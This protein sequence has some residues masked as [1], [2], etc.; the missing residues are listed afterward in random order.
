MEGFDAAVE[1]NKIPIGLWG[2][3]AVNWILDN[4]G[5]FIDAITEGLRVPINGS[6]DLL[7]AIPS[8]IFI[9]IAAAVTYAL[10]RSWKLVLFVVLGLL[11]ILNPGL[12]KELVAPLVLV[13]YA[14]GLA[15]DIDLRSEEGRAGGGW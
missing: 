13:I 10:Q 6:V 3:Y 8:P 12:W 11:L 2:R 1:G 9:L 15:L 14:T 5:V 7:D 4:F